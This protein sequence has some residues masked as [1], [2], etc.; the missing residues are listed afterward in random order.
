MNSND[1]LFIVKECE[2]FEAPFG[3]YP[4]PQ[5]YY[6]QTIIFLPRNNKRSLRISKL[7]KQVGIFDFGMFL[8]ESLNNQE[9]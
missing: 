6:D 3:L 5:P 7:F 9:H 2:H 4:A 8:L 1:W